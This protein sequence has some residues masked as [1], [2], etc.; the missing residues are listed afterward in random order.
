[1]AEDKSVKINVE[2]NEKDIFTF[3]L[4]HAYS[5]ISGILSLIFGV[6]CLVLAVNSLQYDSMYMTVLL[7]VGALLYLVVS[8]IM[9]WFRSK[10]QKENPALKFPITYNIS[11]KGLGLTQRNETTV[12]EWQSIVKVA[13]TKDNLLFYISKQQSFIIPKRILGEEKL[14]L[15][16][17]VII[18]NVDEKKYKFK[19]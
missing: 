8:P 13:E 6:A 11:N 5:R 3:L 14:E 18:E 15:A 4:H 16:K 10:K 7:S 17:E 9:V 2:L 1:M 19:K 12:L